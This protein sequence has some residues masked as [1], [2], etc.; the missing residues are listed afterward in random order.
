MFET[1]APIYREALAK[2]G[3]EYELK[4][5]PDAANPRSKARNRKRNIL[6]YKPPFNL[7]VKSNIAS[8]FLKLLDRSFLHGHPLRKLLNRNTVKVSY[9]CN[10]NMEK[11]ITSRNSKLLSLMSRKEGR[12]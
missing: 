3:Y 4:F 7:S 1:A 8:D 9:S 6:W 11:I 5:D 12:Y 10:P 2:S